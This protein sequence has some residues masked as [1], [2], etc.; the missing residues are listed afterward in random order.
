MDQDP[1][2]QSKAKEAFFQEPLTP[3]VTTFHVTHATHELFATAE[4]SS[5]R[6]NSVWIFNHNMSVANFAGVSNLCKGHEQGGGA[7]C[8]KASSPG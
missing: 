3:L 4:G 8:Y 5:R 2:G 6:I 7:H 1:A